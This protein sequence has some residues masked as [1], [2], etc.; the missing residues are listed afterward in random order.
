LR[1]SAEVK[2]DCPLRLAL[3]L[4]YV[5]VLLCLFLGCGGDPTAELIAQLDDADAAVRRAAVRELAAIQVGD[6][7]IETALARG[8]AD[9]DPEVRRLSIDALA[10]RG[11]AARPALP[12][13]TAALDDPEPPLHTRA[14][15]AIVRIDPTSVKARDA[16]IAAM[17]A[18][19]GRTLLAVGALGE[20]AAWAV[21]TLVELLTHELPAVRTLA[22]KTLGRIGP[23]ALTTAA[24][25]LQRAANDPHPAVQAAANA[26]LERLADDVP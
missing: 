2:G 14:A 7:R 20:D 13:L 10:E 18:A 11:P 26:A 5:L 9:D 12:A 23:I 24:P 3:R 22:A 21:P 17:R 19:D 16:L 4:A 6:P 8:V 15:L 1:R 25:A